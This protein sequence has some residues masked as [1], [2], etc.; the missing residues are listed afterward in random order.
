MT[1]KTTTKVAVVLL[2]L[3]SLALHVSLRPEFHALIQKKF[4]AVMKSSA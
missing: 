3:L 2:Y 4:S 1:M